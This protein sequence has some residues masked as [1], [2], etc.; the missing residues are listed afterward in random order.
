MK[1]QLR[2]SIWRERLIW[3][4]GSDVSV[5]GHLSPFWGD[6]IEAE[7]LGGEW[8]RMAT[9]L[10]SWWLGREGGGEDVS[11]NVLEATGY[12]PLGPSP[13]S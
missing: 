8:W 3:A 4:P 6:S 12:S 9:R 11:E 13:F 10:N 2:K 1:A 5:Q 7:H